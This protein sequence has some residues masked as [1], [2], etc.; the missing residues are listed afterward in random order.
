[1]THLEFRRMPIAGGYAYVVERTGD[2]EFTAT[3]RPGTGEGRNPN[4][5]WR[6]SCQTFDRPQ[7]FGTA[8]TL[9]EAQQ[10]VRLSYAAIEVGNV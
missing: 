4:A 9:T 7:D 8:R 10:A 2:V 1:M 3:V 5:G 6:W